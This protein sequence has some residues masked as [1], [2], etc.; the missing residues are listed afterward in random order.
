MSQACSALAPS[1]GSFKAIKWDTTFIIHA[2]NTFSIS[3]SVLLCREDTEV[4]H[5]YIFTLFEGVIFHFA[6]ATL[7]QLFRNSLSFDWHTKI[8]FLISVMDAIFNFVTPNLL[9]IN[10]EEYHVCP[11]IDRIQIGQVHLWPSLTQPNEVYWHLDSIF[12]NRHSNR[13]RQNNLILQNRIRANGVFI[14]YLHFWDDKMSTRANDTITF[15]S[16][17]FWWIVSI[18]LFS[19]CC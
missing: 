2:T 13:F 12:S 9:G 3:M 8:R 16:L 5:L 6:T 17:S 14:L 18:T 1:A 15:H 4:T 10:K 7:F 11:V 19:R